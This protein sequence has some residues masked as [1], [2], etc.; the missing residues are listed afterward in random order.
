MSTRIVVNTSDD[1]LVTRPTLLDLEMGIVLK[2][3]KGPVN[4]P[5]RLTS[6]SDLK[7]TFGYGNSDYQVL[8]VASSLLSKYRA[9]TICRVACT[10]TVPASAN[11]LSSA[12]EVLFTLNGLNYGSDDN[13]LQI[14]IDHAN[15]KYTVTSQKSINS[16]ITTIEVLSITAKTVSQLC[17]EINTRS[18]VLGAVFVK[19][20]IPVVDQVFSLAG[21]VNGVEVSSDA[22]KAA[23]DAFG[24]SSVSKID[25][26]CAP[27]LNDKE[28]V[29]EG[30]KVASSRLETSYLADFAPDATAAE[31][32][33]IVSTYPH[34]KRV[35]YYH[36]GVVMAIGSDEVIVP[37]S[38]AA[39]FTWGYAATIAPW[40]SP[41]GFTSGFEL[42]SVTRS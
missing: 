3:P 8:T 5:T 6:E 17:K 12:D 13:G 39:L 29:E 36:P 27:G 33:S 37:A 11:I 19:E 18:K 42:P 26:I 35:A 10:D 7:S 23:L 31:V 30:V 9:L 34:D 1:T 41:A 16:V 2:A 14:K 38:A 4:K 22:V 24:S 32:L 15:D 28:V 40:T 21:G 25:V 20:G